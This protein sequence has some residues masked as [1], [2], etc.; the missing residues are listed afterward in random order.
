MIYNVSTFYNTSERVASLLV[1]V[2]NQ[3]IR[4]CKSHITEGGR[5]TLWNQEREIIEEKLT[6]C[7]KLNDAYR[8]AYNK[9][10]DR[11]VGSE[12]REFSFS[13]KYIFGRF[14]SFCTRMRNL[15]S[16]FKKIS[17]YSGLFQ[18]RME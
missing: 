5:V 14:D 18:N 17:L 13:Q 10:K 7:I 6:Q 3:V 8:D 2:T 1:K 12:V 16:M 11:N 15:L 9:V 4:S